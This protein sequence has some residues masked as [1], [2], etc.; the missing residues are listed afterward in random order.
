M[1]AQAALLAQQCCDM[2]TA[3]RTRKEIVE[4]IFGHPTLS[5]VVLAAA[6]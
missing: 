3:R 1:G 4:T 6:Q 5:E 2:I